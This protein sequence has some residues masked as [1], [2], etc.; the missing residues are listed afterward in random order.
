MLVWL[1]LVGI[2]L[3][4]AAGC[5]AYVEGMRFED[6]G[7]GSLDGRGLAV[8]LS[9]GLTGIPLGFLEY[10]ILRPDSWL[11]GPFTLPALVGGTLVLLVAT[12]VSEE[13]IF[14]GI[15]LRRAVE[16]LGN[17]KGLFLTTIVFAVLHLFYRS[18]ADFV[19]VFFVGLF[20]G[21]VVLR[22]RSLWGVIVSHTFDNVVLYLVAP[23][24]F[25]HVTFP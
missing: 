21:V 23:F 13:V 2:P 7:F 22:T 15:L 20:Y 9:I 14:R 24:L 17:Y 19:F 16:F 12:G 25:A 8:Q 5:V 6:L 1:G 3:V 18:P 10:A 11:P 4:V